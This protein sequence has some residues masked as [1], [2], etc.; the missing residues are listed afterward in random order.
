MVLNARC[1]D[2]V[3]LVEAAYDLGCI[4]SAW[5]EQVAARA[6]AAVAGATG[7]VAYSFDATD[8]AHA[9]VVGATHGHGALE[10]VRAETLQQ[11][12]D[13]MGPQAAH[14][15]HPH[16]VLIGRISKL[17]HELGV[18]LGGAARRELEQWAVED[19]LALVGGSPQGRG[20]VVAVTAP[21]TWTL[22]TR[23]MRGWHALTQHL[24]TGA[25]VRR[26]PPPLRV[27]PGPMAVGA[28]GAAFNV[29]NA[30]GTPTSAPTGVSLWH[31]LLS[32]EWSLLSHHATEAN[33]T[34]VA[35]RNGAGPADPRRVTPAVRD[36]LEL[37]AQG[38]DNVFIGQHLDLS[39]STTATQLAEGLRRLGLEDRTQLMVLYRALAGPRGGGMSAASSSLATRPARPSTP[40]F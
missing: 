34:L 14:A 21:S 29:R 2:A 13:G 40:S 7:V 39:P 31:G 20:V 36:V 32:G 16:Q 25:S 12:F 24:A 33:R 28:D 26:A 17:T 10:N 18:H 1:Q 9:P 38:Y 30:P 4:E 23:A 19:T 5:L 8:K 37:A 22:S 11:F 35:R 27:A 6:R 3:G 15:M